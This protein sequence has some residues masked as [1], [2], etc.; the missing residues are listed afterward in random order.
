MVQQAR[1]EKL[2]ILFSDLWRVDIRVTGG[3]I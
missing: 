1:K 2:S 3:I